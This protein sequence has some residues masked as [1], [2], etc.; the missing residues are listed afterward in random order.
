MELPYAVK[1]QYPISGVIYW[2]DFSFFLSLFTLVC[3]PSHFLDTTVI[4]RL[5]L[6]SL[7]HRVHSVSDFYLR[8]VPVLEGSSCFFVLLPFP[9]V[10]VFHFS[11]PFFILYNFHISSSPPLAVKFSQVQLFDITPP[12]IIYQVTTNVYY[13]LNIYW[14]RSVPFFFFPCFLL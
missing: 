13:S 1:V 2:R 6:S 12:P 4:V 5:G 14:W 9:S 3:L 8:K 11:F 10:F 7:I